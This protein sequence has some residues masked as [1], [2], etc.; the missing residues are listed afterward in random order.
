MG[1]E[2]KNSDNTQIQ[3]I[4]ANEINNSTVINV[5][6]YKYYLIDE[7]FILKIKKDYESTKLAFKRIYSNPRNVINQTT[8]I[9]TERDVV[10]FFILGLILMLLTWLVMYSFAP[11]IMIVPT[12]F[13]VLSINFMTTCQDK[14]HKKRNHIIF[15]IHLLANLTLIGLCFFRISY[16]ILF[17]STFILTWII[18]ISGFAV[19]HSVFS[20]GY[21]ELQDF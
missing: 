21:P 17:G 14:K 20:C 7:K 11:I 13:E 18:F 10:S 8:L 3:G 6:K 19:F 2:I 15:L 12:I 16:D 5:N 1:N 4:Q 9:K